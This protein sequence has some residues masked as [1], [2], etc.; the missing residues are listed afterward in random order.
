MPEDHPKLYVTDFSNTPGTQ[1]WREQQEHGRVEG[2]RRYQDYL[3]GVFNE[4]GVADSE[5]LADATLS[6]LFDWR[7][8]ATGERCRCT[9]HPRLADGDQHDYGF[10]CSCTHNAQQRREA[11]ERRRAAIEASWTSP[12]ALRRAGER[13]AETKELHAWL[14]TQPGVS[15]SSRG[16]LYPEQWEGTVDG[17]SFYF[18]E[19]WDDW[20]IELDLKPSGRFAKA[21]TGVDDRQI[22]TKETEILSGEVIASGDIYVDGYGETPMQRAQFIVDT[23]RVHLARQTCTHHGGDLSRVHDILDEQI[24]WC[25]LCGARLLGVSVASERQATFAAERAA[26]LADNAEGEALEGRGVRQRLRQAFAHVAERSGE[27]YERLK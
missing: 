18:R 16:G 25:P 5:A 15:V 23:I 1:R 17:R 13:D 22:E 24:R 4:R 19:R 7:S 10:G 8:V 27:L 11:A 14:D 12:Q 20:R 21:V 2:R 26:T 6:A 9:C 3:A